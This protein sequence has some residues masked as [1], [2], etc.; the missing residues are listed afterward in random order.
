MGKGDKS[1]WRNV[2][3]THQKIHYARKGLTEN[4]KIQN[5]GKASLTKRSR[6]VRRLQQRRV[7]IKS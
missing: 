4:G 1:L 3:R 5:G 6:A 7:G 2:N